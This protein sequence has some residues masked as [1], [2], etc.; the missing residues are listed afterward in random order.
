MVHLFDAW[1]HT[2]FRAENFLIR[3]DQCFVNECLPSRLN[4]FLDFSLHIHSIELCIS[5]VV[6][7]EIHFG[8]ATVLKQGEVASSRGNI[9]RANGSLDKF[10]DPAPVC[11]G[12]A[13]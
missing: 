11:F 12:D 5:K 6:K 3:Q 10:F 8:L 7:S 9:K 4:Y 2:S 1:P 13:S